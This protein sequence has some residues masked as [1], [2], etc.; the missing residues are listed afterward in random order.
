MI[1]IKI[2]KQPKTQRRLHNIVY[3]IQTIKFHKLKINNQRKRLFST[4][5]NPVLKLIKLEVRNIVNNYM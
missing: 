5:I 4:K 3:Q 2:F 1:K